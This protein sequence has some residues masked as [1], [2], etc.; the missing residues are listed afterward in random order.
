MKK[1]T[2]TVLGF[3]VAPL[4]PSIYG[5]LA[6]PITR[7]FDLFTQL[8]LIPAFY[9]YAL[10]FTIVF[11]VPAFLL[12]QYFHLVRWWTAFVG[13][14]LIGAIVLVVVHLPGTPDARDFMETC[15]LGGVSGFVFWLVWKCGREPDNHSKK[16]P[17][18]ESN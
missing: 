2:A 5:A 8:P 3:V 9:G 14:V 10:L 13:G 7:N 12:I 11:G 4:I 17:S 16:A 6:T 15:P 1:I 18:V